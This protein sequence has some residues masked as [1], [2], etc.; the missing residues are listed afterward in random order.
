MDKIF[1]A[2]EKK[3]KTK[4]DL[5]LYLEGVSL[6]KE[7]V[8]NQDF[9][10]FKETDPQLKEKIDQLLNYLKNKKERIRFKKEE[11]ESRKKELIRKEK[12]WREKKREI[13]E[14]YKEEENPDNK[15]RYRR[16][17]REAEKRRREKEEKIWDLEDKIIQLEKETQEGSQKDGYLEVKEQLSLLGE[18]ED[19]LFSLPELRLEM[20]KKPDEETISLIR[21]WFK[22]N[23]NRPVV[24][25]IKINSKLVAGAVVEY[26]GKWAD[27]SLSKRMKQINYPHLLEKT[28]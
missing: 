23:F 7:A 27:F 9:D 4:E 3:V 6:L 11:M 5:N 20:A 21:N 14:K 8:H 24:L 10:D 17:K 13:S 25:I 18:I 19:Y 28:L 22:D 26:E 1:S 16:E 12:E 2:L 15:N